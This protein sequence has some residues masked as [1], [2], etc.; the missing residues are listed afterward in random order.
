MDRLETIARKRRVRNGKASLVS[1]LVPFTPEKNSDHRE[2]VWRW[3]EARWRATVPDAEIVVGVDPGTPPGPYSKTSAINDAY[4]RASGDVFV[5]ADADAWLEPKAF[6][7]AVDVA[8]RTNKLVVP[9]RFVHRLSEE[10]TDRIIAGDPSAKVEMTPDMMM[11]A[12]N[13]P[14]PVTAGTLVVISR[15]AF[16]TVE[17]MD[18]RFRGWGMEDVAFGRAC[19]TI[20]GPNVYGNEEVISLYHP[21]PSLEQ[22]G[23]VWD[24]EDTDV[25]VSAH[26]NLELAKLY[27]GAIRDPDKMLAIVRQHRLREAKIPLTNSMDALR[28]VIDFDAVTFIE[29]S[30]FFEDRSWTTAIQEVDT[31]LPINGDDETFTVEIY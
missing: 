2:R 23:R 6:H 17:G 4:R 29:P 19:E 14:D 3:I 9:W 22:R 21:R 10:D 11:A 13:G 8:R 30:A 31:A 25:P 15:D 16:E 24:G 5:I 20:L 27:D 7:R 12:F 18:P 26:P 1:I 28:Q